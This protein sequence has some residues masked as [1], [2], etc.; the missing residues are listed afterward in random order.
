MIMLIVL[1]CITAGVYWLV[2]LVLY[3]VDEKF[4]KS[5]FDFWAGFFPGY[6]W[7]LSAKKMYDQRFD[8]HS[9]EYQNYKGKGR[10]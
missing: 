2:S 6:H 1:G 8:K 4:V 3:T 7:F 10:L 9:N 5:K